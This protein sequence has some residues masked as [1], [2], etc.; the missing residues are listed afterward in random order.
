MV[1][2]LAVSMICK[3]Y[4]QDTVGLDIFS[5]HERAGVRD[6]SSSEIS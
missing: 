3:T 6:Q 2:R 4:S 5:K 1:Q